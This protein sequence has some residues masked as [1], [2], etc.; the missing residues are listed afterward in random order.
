MRDLGTLGGV[1]SRAVAINERGQILGTRDTGSVDE[2]DRSISHAFVWEKG[3]MRD[4]GTLGGLNSYA[5]AISERGQIVGSSEPG[6]GAERHGHDSRSRVPLGE[7]EDDR[8]RDPPRRWLVPTIWARSLIAFAFMVPRS[9]IVP[10]D[11]RNV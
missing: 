7:G 1:N 4:L 10:F 6:D 2:D 9:R 8:P 3:K 5:D 11:Q